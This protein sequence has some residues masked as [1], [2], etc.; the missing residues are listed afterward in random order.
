MKLS[1]QQKNLEIEVLD[2]QQ[3]LFFSTEKNAIKARKALFI[4]LEIFILYQYTVGY[5]FIKSN[6]Q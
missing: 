4:L 3:Q 6:R 5:F 2:H 1:F